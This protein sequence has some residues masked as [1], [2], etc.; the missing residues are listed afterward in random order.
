MGCCTSKPET[1][2]PA[3]GSVTYTSQHPTQPS[4][5][6]G[7]SGG[8]GQVHPVSP[9]RLNIAHHPQPQQMQI[10]GPMGQQ[11]SGP[12]APRFGGQQAMVGQPMIGGPMRP[13]QGGALTF[14]ALYNYTARTAEDLSF[15]KGECV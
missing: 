14:V 15:V 5:G 1:P 2:K 8:V 6:M 10:G 11:R 7:R 13:Q 3:A 12:F 4:P 9:G